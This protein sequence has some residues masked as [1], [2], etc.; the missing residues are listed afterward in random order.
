MSEAAPLLSVEGLEIRR[1]DGRPIVAAADFAIAA[2]EIVLLLGPSGSGK[3]TL[4]RLFAGLLDSAA[5]WQ[6]AG[7]CTLP[8]GAVDLASDRVAAGSIVFQDYALFDDLTVRGNLAIGVDHGSD[9]GSD[10]RDF[11][12]SLLSGIDENQRV[13]ELS[14]GQRQRVAIARSLLSG[15]PL[16]FFDEPNAG[17]DAA[18]VHRLTDL[19][20]RLR[21]ERGLAMVIVAHHVHELLP[22]VDRVLLLDPEQASLRELAPDAPEL[23]DHA[24]A[25]RPRAPAAATADVRGGTRLR[26]RALPGWWLRYAAQYFYFL[27][28]APSMLSFIF[29]GGLL[30]GFVS[31]WSAFRFMPF[32]E[33]LLPLVHDD[34]LTAIG[35]TQFRV[36]APLMLSILIAARNSAIIAA[37]IGH[38]VYTRQ[39]EAMVSLNISHR[40]YLVGGVLASN[41]AGALLLTLLMLAVTVAAT[42]LTW[43]AGFPDKPAAL[44]RDSFFVL[45]FRGGDWLPDGW[46][47]MLAKVLAS[48]LASAAVGLY[49]GYRPKTSVLS[50]NAAI[51]Q[52][53][54]FGVS[55][56]LAVNA[57]ITLVEP[58]RV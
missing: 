29:V 26:P 25:W 16:I 32:A 10:L 48:A 46:P 2:G 45:V 5:G 13:A 56:T 30:T 37:D 17:L 8:D 52:A 58:I 44:F 12:Q 51:A 54:I 34:T 23:A 47:W 27:A 20:D 57:L 1:P 28:L 43:Q 4:L 14:G 49:F 19:L 42:L 9:V 53:I 15:R 55:I 7:R 21:R 3:S 33:Y 39:V 22:I 38:R 24:G 11:A 31:A 35:L 41:V 18:Q 36:L 6:V 40:A 50:I